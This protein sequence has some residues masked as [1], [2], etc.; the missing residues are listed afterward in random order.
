MSY[1]E[2]AA[3]EFGVG[4][5]L[6]LTLMGLTPLQCVKFPALLGIQKPSMKSLGQPQP[7]VQL[8]LSVCSHRAPCCGIC[9]IDPD[10]HSQGEGTLQGPHTAVHTHDC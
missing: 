8:Q 9:L 6:T 10:G 1:M 2:E 3:S 4:V 7:V 5:H